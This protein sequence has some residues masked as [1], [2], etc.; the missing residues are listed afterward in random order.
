MKKIFATLMLGAVAFSSCIKEDDTYKDL[1]PVQPG[2]YIYSYVMTQDRVAMQ[3]ASAGMRVAVL[4]AEVAKQQAEGKD[5]VTLSTVQ[6]NGRTVLSRLFNTATKIEEVADGYKLTFDKNY[7]M[8]DGFYL[9]GSL[10]VQTGGAA[11]L[12]DGAEWNV[13]MQP[14]FKLFSYSSYGGQESQINMY[15]GVTRLIDNGDGSYAIRLSNITAAVEGNDTATSNWSSEGAGFVVRPRDEG[16]TLAYS[17]CTGKVFEVEGSASGYSIYSNVY[18]T[19]PLGMEYS[20]TEGL[21]IG[22]QIVSGTQVCRFSSSF[23]YDTSAYPAPDVRY[24]YSFD[25][26]NRQYSF[27]IYYNGYTYPKD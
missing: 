26:A 11:Q 18:G 3:A 13:V 14:D 7:Q 15:S 2:Q 17:S 12:A 25:E 19:S 4:A 20:V 27:K 9:S 21:Y 23:D 16:V 1:L 24:V 8:P 22:Q 6:S 5:D 10:L